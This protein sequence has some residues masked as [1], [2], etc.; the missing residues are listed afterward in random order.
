MR[1]Y[2]TDRGVR[3]Q[4]RRYQRVAGMT[5][6]EAAFFKRSG[7]LDLPK[8]TAD[9]LIS[10]GWASADPNHPLV[11][12]RGANAPVFVPEP[13]E[14]E[15]QVVEVEHTT[16]IAEKPPEIESDGLLDTNPTEET[17]KGEKPPETAEKADTKKADM[18]QK[19]RK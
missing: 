5:R 11:E 19:R 1:V 16:K 7:A 3:C 15:T 4:R 12:G 18:K 6:Q 10:K 2:V 13:V 17:P 9:I 14:L 8:N